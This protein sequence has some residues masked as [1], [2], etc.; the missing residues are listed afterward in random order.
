M[1]DGQVTQRK[2]DASAF[3]IFGV[4]GDLAH[5]L[6][7]PSL[8][9]L[10]AANLLP[11]KFCVVGVARNGMSND[12]LRD[13][14]MKGLRQFATRPVD[15]TV[16]KRLLECV[17][18]IEADPKDPASFDAMRAQLDELEC[19][20]DQ[21]AATGCFI[22]PRRQAPSRRS[23]ASSAAPVCCRKKTAPGAGWWWKSRSGPISLRPER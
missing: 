13:S 18:C 6:V 10:A 3:V 23:P 17:T 11:G 15:D 12:Q 9:N 19:A 4:T 22:S 7:V 16:A 2:P 21:P 1:P 8:Y 5:R 14:L 20:R